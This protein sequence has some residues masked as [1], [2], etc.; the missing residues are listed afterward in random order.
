MKKLLKTL[1][2]LLLFVL[3]LDLFAWLTIRHEFKTDRPL[4]Y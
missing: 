1:L 3:V 4:G 2:P